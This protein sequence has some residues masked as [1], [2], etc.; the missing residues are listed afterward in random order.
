[1]KLVA[2]LPPFVQGDVRPSDECKCIMID[3]A[4]QRRKGLIYLRYGAKL[5]YWP[6]TS[7]EDALFW[8]ISSTCETRR[9]S[10]GDAMGCFN[11]SRQCRIDDSSRRTI[12]RPVPK[13]ILKIA[14]QK[15]KQKQNSAVLTDDRTSIDKAISSQRQLHCKMSPIKCKYEPRLRTKVALFLLG[16]LLPTVLR[17]LLQGAMQA[18][19]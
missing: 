11:K 7:I 16:P 12:G 15:S 5:E 13:L 1:M 18:E 3:L 19:I 4:V 17:E 8:A 9:T 2:V 10:V 6:P 14:P